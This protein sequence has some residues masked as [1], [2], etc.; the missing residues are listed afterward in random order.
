MAKITLNNGHFY[1]VD[2][3]TQTQI[4]KKCKLEDVKLIVEDMSQ[5]NVSNAK[6]E[7]DNKI[8]ALGNLKLLSFNVD[9]EAVDY[10][11]TLFFKE[12]PQSEIDLA[13]ERAKSEALRLCA[14]AGLNVLSPK[15]VIQWCEFLDPWNE[16][17]FPYKK[18]ERFK[19][20]NKPYEVKE[21]VI[22]NKNE[23]PEKALRYYK[24]VTVEDTY[25][26]YDKNKIY[27]IGDIVRHNGKL[28]ISKWAD[29][30]NHEPSISS[31]WKE[32]DGK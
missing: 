19:H 4:G 32:W 6:V 30:K 11:I 12:V 26:D 5:E 2:Y 27:N 17:K 24:E 22:S 13:K 23:P 20:N 25:K 1:T 28:W 10:R 29:N 15:F 31:A 9:K 16:Y 21:D 14:V 8:T 18:G 7:G 3:L